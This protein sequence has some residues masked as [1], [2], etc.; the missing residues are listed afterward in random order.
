MA[1]THNMHQKKRIAGR[2]TTTTSRQS[3]G[4]VGRD[5]NWNNTGPRPGTAAERYREWETER[6]KHNYKKENTKLMMCNGGT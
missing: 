1:P 5:S 3:I 4:Q 6:V 2:K